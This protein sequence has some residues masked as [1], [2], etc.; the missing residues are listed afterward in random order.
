ML[1]NIGLLTVENRFISSC[2]L[3]E[4]IADVAAGNFEIEDL[5]MYIRK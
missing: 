3:N 5:K 4:I 1:G 2:T